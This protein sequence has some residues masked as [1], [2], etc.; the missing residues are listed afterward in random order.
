MIE[1]SIG[2]HQLILAAHGF[3]Q[4]FLF[5]SNAFLGQLLL[6]DNSSTER[7]ERVEQAHHE[8]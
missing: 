3:A 6:A 7:V 4:C 5:E 1:P 2:R 8:R